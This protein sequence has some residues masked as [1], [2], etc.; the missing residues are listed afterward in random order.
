MGKFIDM[1]CYAK[2]IFFRS[3]HWFVSVKARIY[4]GSLHE[5]RVWQLGFLKNKIHR[6]IHGLMYRKARMYTASVKKI[7]VCYLN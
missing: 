1:V 6:S 4:A 3:I 7:S 5:R 2:F